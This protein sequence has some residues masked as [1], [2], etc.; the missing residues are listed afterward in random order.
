MAV[1]QLPRTERLR[2]SIASFLE[3]FNGPYAAMETDP[4]VANFAVG[5]PHEKAMPQ[6]VQAIRDHLE[7]QDKDWFAY[8]MSEP[9]ARATVARTMSALTHLDWD[10]QDIQMTNGGFG[11]LAVAFRTLLDEGDEAI[12]LS[13]PWF[14]YEH[15]ILAA[16]ATPV[17]VDFEMPECELDVA[18]IEAAITSRTRVVVVNSPHNPSGRVL[19]PDQLRALADMLTH[20]SARVGHAIFLVSDEPYRRIVFDGRECHSPSEFYAHT[21]VTYSY[22]KQLLAPGMRIGYITWPPTMARDERERLRDDVF[23]N[24]LAGGWAF[25]NA[26]LQHSLPDL[27]PLCIDLGVLERRRERVVN[28]LRSVGYEASWPEGTFY[29]M[30]RSPIAD[31]VRFG[32]LLNERKVLVLPGAIVHTPGWFRISLTA[33]D[34]MVERGLPAFESAIREVRERR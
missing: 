22:G 21:I 4:Q 18:A 12:Y 23:V 20:A 1:T 10:G 9:G 34:E 5:N 17:R 25:P 11:A 16:G 28:H 24:Q 15:L 30:A 32:A 31:D 26:D 14:F 7:P 19:P 33:S 2:A 3:F 8:K 29:V 13:P 27:E 6:F